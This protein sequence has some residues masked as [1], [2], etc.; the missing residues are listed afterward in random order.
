M[1]ANAFAFDVF[2][3]HSSKDKAVVHPLAERLKA[4]GLRV[5]F[6]TWEIRVGD[7]IPAKIE[8]GL[9]RSGVVVLCMSANAFGSDWATLESQT[10]RFRDPLNRER[11]FIPLRLDDV[12]IKG[13][14]EQFAY[15][16]W[17]KKGQD[18]G[19]PLLLEA[20]RPISRSRATKDETKAEI[21]NFAVPED[22]LKII[23]FDLDPTIG[24]GIY[25]G[26]LRK[27]RED[28]R[29]GALSASI[30]YQKTHRKAQADLIPISHKADIE[31]FTFLEIAA[32]SDR[33]WWGCPQSHSINTLRSTIEML[34]RPVLINCSS[35][36]I[37]AY[38]VL[39]GFHRHGISC[40]IIPDDASGREQAISLIADPR[41][42][43]V[44]CADAPLFLDPHENIRAYSK[45]FEIYNE[46][47]A[48]IRKRG[49]ITPAHPK[50]YVYKRSSAEHQFLLERARDN[51]SPL[52]ENLQEE[53]LLN[54]ADF[55]V[56]SEVMDPGDMIIA[57]GAL[58]ESLLKNPALV[59]VENSNF[60]LTVSMFTHPNWRART[61]A[62][63]AFL[64]LFVA[65]W[66]FCQ[67]HEK[68]TFERLAADARF[69][70]SFARGG[71]FK[72]KFSGSPK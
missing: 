35:V 34:G 15:V 23:P 5:W 10:F 2:L 33:S 29:Q 28:F 55:A 59:K 20:C 50:V 66:N 57:W 68:V 41:F 19:Y 22:Y 43:F 21:S 56:V 44:V 32:I 40:E 64:D 39:K 63:A 45:L 37:A 30:M 14:L 24:P 71:G 1:S 69:M 27:L 58:K 42:D 53:P 47:Q 52:P 72:T 48:V 60:A 65:E 25:G 11:R 16:D 9:E 4:D 51:E 13:S 62:L 31:R 38:A 46:D 12:E 18:G 26:M 49:S 70:D 67:V 54:M 6:D 61:N 17:R 7:S 36:N 8:E 3:S